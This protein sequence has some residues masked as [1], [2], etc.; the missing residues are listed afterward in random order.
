MRALRRTAVLLFVLLLTA[1]AGA[2]P[3]SAGGP[4]SV[5]LSAP[6]LERVAALHYSDSAYERLMQVVDGQGA[7][8]ETASAN[9]EHRQVGDVVRATWLIHDVMVWRT[10]Q[11][12]PDAPG[13]PWIGTTLRQ[14]GGQA[15]QADQADKVVWHRPANPGALVAVLSSLGML[16]GPRVQQPPIDAPPSTT[17]APESAP[18]PAPAAASVEAGG[19][20]GW[21]WAVPGFVAGGLLA[22]VAVHLLANRRQDDWELIDEVE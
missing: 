8:T 20:A 13:G 22:A 19:L 21:R 5:L 10:D 3:A 7:A 17:P 9:S 12:Y 2:G 4:T 1:V 16:G 15:D 18:E 14:D 11:I 6:N